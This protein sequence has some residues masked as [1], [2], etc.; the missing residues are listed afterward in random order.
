MDVFLA[1]DVNKALNLK[2]IIQRT[3]EVNDK[4][5]EASPIKLNTTIDKDARNNFDSIVVE[6]PPK[7]R[8]DFQRMSTF[9]DQQLE[10]PESSIFHVVF[11]KDGA[12]QVSPAYPTVANTAADLA[13]PE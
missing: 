6:V 9:G 7:Q 8:K 10:E 4:D 1:S 3:I 13:G 5:R 11:N 2:P 12:A